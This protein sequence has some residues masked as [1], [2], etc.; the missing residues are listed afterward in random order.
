MKAILIDD[1]P[2]ALE[3]LEHLINKTS[4]MVI[5]EK[6]TFFD[7]QKDRSLL[8][9]VDLIFLDIE[10]PEV[11][12]LELAEKILEVNPLI[13]IIFVT[14]FH[15]YAVQAFELNA[16]D[17]L[18]KPV[19]LDRLQKTLERLDKNIH[20]SDTEVVRDDGLHI[21]VCG[22]LSFQQEDNIEMIKWRTAKAQELFL[23]LLHEEGKTIRKAEIVDRLWPNF[24]VEKAY[25]HLY[26]TIYHIRKTLSKFKGHFTIKSVQD[27]YILLTNNV[28]I[29]KIEWEVNVR[30]AFPIH[31]HTIENVEALMEL[32]T[33]PY[34]ENYE[35]I[36]AEAERFRLEQLWLKVAHRM[37]ACY[38]E[39]RE[40]DKA[41][42]W[43]DKICKANPDHE[44]ANFSLIKLYA[45]LG[46]GLLAKH[47]FAQL[48]SA[49][50]DLGFDVDEDIKQW[51]TEW[52]NGK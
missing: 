22:D 11:N 47:Q 51:Y 8:D 6:L 43:Y 2:L 40:V 44:L 50:N 30:D 12:G 18:L 48:E 38:E 26:T 28:T 35:Y 39:N 29:D 37:A 45:E 17:Y 19:Q 49:M 4:H 41:I 14:A 1:E 46:Y 21:K 33:A 10:M 16:L 9:E 24:E 15:D 32:Y 13:E 42:T 23:Y 20:N 5:V 27:G 36:W 52:V 3:Y 25:S 34:L 31:I 7:I